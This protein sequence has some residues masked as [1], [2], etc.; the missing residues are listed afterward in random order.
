MSNSHN[1]YILS[2]NNS[3]TSTWSDGEEMMVTIGG[4]VDKN[5]I[6]AIIDSMG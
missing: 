5:D 1:F 2:N 3:Y 6:K 4:E